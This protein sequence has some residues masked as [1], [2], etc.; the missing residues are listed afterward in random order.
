MVQLNVEA[1]RKFHIGEALSDAE[2]RNLVHFYEQ[3]FY[4]LDQL[5]KEFKLAAN[6]CRQRLHTLQDYQSARQEK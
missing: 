4:H 3:C 2:L 6:E 1:N 5:G